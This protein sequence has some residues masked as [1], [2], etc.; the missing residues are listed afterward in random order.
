[1]A[2]SH[3]VVT[4][5]G[6]QANFT[7]RCAD[8]IAASLPKRAWQRLSAGQASKGPRFYDWAW[9]TINTTRRRHNC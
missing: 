5:A 7:K 8:V 2:C 4:G 1:M 6:K 9:V 3:Q